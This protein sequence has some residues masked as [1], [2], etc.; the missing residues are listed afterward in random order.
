MSGRNW[1]QRDPRDARDPIERA[2][3]A[4]NRRDL[5]VTD[6]LRGEIESLLAHDAQSFLESP[7]AQLLVVAGPLLDRTLMVNRQIGPYTIVA[8]LGSGGMGEG[9][10]RARQQT[11]PRRSDQDPAAVLDG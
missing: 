1:L 10:S 9:L 7:A 6:A 2:I 5:V 4:R 3:K 8:P 11:W